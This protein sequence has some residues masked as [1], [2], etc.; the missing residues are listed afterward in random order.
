MESETELHHLYMPEK[1]KGCG[2]VGG[3]LWA[4][5]AVTF[6]GRQTDQVAAIVEPDL[7]HDRLLC[8]YSTMHSIGANAVGPY[9]D[10]LF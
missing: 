4:P 9:T 2:S 1:P 5:L 7:R 10:H 8:A 6:H 3:A